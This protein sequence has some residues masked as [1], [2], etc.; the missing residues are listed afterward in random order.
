[1]T[2]LLKDEI[3]DAIIEGVGEEWDVDVIYGS[4]QNQIVLNDHEP[5]VVLNDDVILPEDL[6]GMAS[7]IALDVAAILASR[8]SC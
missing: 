7:G 3:T 6:R 1:M 2:K 5:I 8:S 4:T